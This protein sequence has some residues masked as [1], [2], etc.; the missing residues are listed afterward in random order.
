MSPDVTIQSGGCGV[1][2][3]ALGCCKSAG[4]GYQTSGSAEL[5]FVIQDN[6]AGFG[7]AAARKLLNPN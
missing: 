1:S 5:V 6:G 2:P 7:M 3:M 4:S